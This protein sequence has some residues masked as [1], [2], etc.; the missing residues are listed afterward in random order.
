MY[1]CIKINATTVYKYNKNVRLSE[2]FKPGLGGIYLYWDEVKQPS[3]SL[4]N[5]QHFG[6][7]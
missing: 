3:E 1:I 7:K 6:T 4:A 5:K 2:S